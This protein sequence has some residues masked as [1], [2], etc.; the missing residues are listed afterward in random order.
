MLFEICYYYV[1]Y[2]RSEVVIKITGVID[3]TVIDCIG[4][5][6]DQAKERIPILLMRY[7]TM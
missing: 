2:N 6:V 1:E 4:E 5:Y 3:M 7:I